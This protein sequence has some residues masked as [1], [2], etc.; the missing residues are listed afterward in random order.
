MNVFFSGSCFNDEDLPERVLANIDGG[1]NVMMSH[2]D[3]HINRAHSLRRFLRLVKQRLEEALT[4]VREG[5][6]RIVH[7]QNVIQTNYRKAKNLIDVE[8]ACP[9]CGRT[10]QWQ[11]NPEGDNSELSIAKANAIVAIHGCPACFSERDGALVVKQQIP[12]SRIDP[13]DTHST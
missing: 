6:T 3:I 13:R 5:E 4:S 8:I 12:L 2:H 10:G 7:D 1:A 11:V 9:F